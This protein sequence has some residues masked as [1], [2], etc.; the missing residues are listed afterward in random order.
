MG[1]RKGNSNYGPCPLKNGMLTQ[2]TGL[3][4]VVQALNTALGVQEENREF[5][6]N[7]E[8]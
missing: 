5:K 4:M 7:L 3:D 1:V 2:G 6:A 8:N